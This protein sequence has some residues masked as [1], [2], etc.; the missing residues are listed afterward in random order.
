MHSGTAANGS[1]GGTIVG[2]IKYNK[3]LF[4]WFQLGQPTTFVNQNK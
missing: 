3:V 2:I 1:T 4:T